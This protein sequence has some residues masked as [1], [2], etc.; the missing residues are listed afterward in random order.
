MQITSSFINYIIPGN[1]KF[2][3][4]LFFIAI[5]LFVYVALRAWLIPFT[6]DEDYTL[7]QFVVKGNIFNSSYELMSANNHLLNTWLMWFMYK[8]FGCNVFML[9][10]PN[11][12]AFGAFL[13]FNGKLLKSIENN[14]L[15]VSAFCLL[16]MNPFLLDFFSLARGY[17]LSVLLMTISVY[18][19]Y[20]FFKSGEQKKIFLSFLFLAIAVLANFTM[21]Y[22]MLSSILIAVIFFFIYKKALNVKQ[23]TILIII[24]ALLLLYSFYVIYMLSR[25]GALFYGGTTGFWYDTVNSIV[26]NTLYEKSYS[27][28]FHLP[29]KIA[30][31]IIIIIATGLTISN[32]IFRD[33]NQPMQIHSILLFVIAICTLLQIALFHFFDIKYLVGRTALF[34]IPLLNMLTIFTLVETI[35]N[36]K[37][38]TAMSLFILIVVAFHF[39]N[40]INLNHVLLWK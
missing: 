24:T 2:Y 12:L 34:Y 7:Y 25:F 33:K 4:V 14:W 10:L 38:L 35:K 31:A 27:L 18:N 8:L 20:L 15:K 26:F 6:W 28:L 30:V 29:V 17:G 40:C 22:V 13:F 36:K 11:V 5:L 23:H 37:M 9:R 39:A 1:K 16:G 19:Y 21:L 32:K 3:A